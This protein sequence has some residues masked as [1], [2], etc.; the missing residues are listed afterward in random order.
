MQNEYLEVEA[1]DSSH[2]IRTETAQAS[3]TFGSGPYQTGRT[4]HDTMT[5]FRDTLKSLHDTMTTLQ[6]TRLR[7]KAWD[8]AMNN[9]KLKVTQLT[10]RIQNEK[11][12]FERARLTEELQRTKERIAEL[13]MIK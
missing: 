9:E 10:Y 6:K 8:W 12:P 13:V 3:F 4:H 1:G 7:R 11:S 2:Q 5:T